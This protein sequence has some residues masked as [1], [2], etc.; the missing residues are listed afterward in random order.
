MRRSTSSQKP[1]IHRHKSRHVKALQH[2]SAHHA[3]RHDV[4]HAAHKSHGH[5]QKHH[6]HHRGH[7]VKHWPK[8]Q[9]QRFFWSALL[10]VLF[11]AAGYI[12]TTRTFAENN[13]NNTIVE[14]NA[15]LLEKY[16][17]LP[18]AVARAVNTVVAT[19]QVT[20]AADKQG[21]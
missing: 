16:P 6:V 18:V 10:V 11:S 7:K 2:S 20:D 5:T 9:K 4:P 21:I 3:D 13:N 15:Q 8:G 17:G 14:T 1:T 12:A 19:Q